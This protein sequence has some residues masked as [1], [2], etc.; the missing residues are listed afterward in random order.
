MKETHRNFVL[1]IGQLQ[2]ISPCHQFSTVSESSLKRF[3]CIAIIMYIVKKNAYLFL[4]TR[5]DLEVMN[6]LLDI[7][8]IQTLHVLH[9]RFNHPAIVYA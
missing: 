6:I 7:V 3:K 9:K 1:C 8:E 2:N 4:I 5:V